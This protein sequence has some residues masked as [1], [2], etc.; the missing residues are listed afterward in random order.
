MLTRLVVVLLSTLALTSC[1]SDYK[2]VMVV[3]MAEIFTPD[4]LLQTTDC[5]QLWSDIQRFGLEMDEARED[6]NQ[7]VL[8][9]A[10]QL[11]EQGCVQRKARE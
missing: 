11:I 10:Y 7:V 2:K 6:W 1:D 4:N 8:N 5:M 3:E 9:N